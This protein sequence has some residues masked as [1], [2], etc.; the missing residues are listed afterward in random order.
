MNLASWAGSRGRLRTALAPGLDRRTRHRTVRAE[1]TTVAGLWLQPR[2]TGLAVIEE[3]AGVRRHCFDGPVAAVGA[4]DGRN[5]DHPRNMPTPALNRQRL[6]NR[7]KSKP[8]HH[9]GCDSLDTS[10][11]GLPRRSTSAVGECQSQE[12]FS[13]RPRH[14]IVGSR[15][16]L[17]MPARLSTSSCACTACDSGMTR[18]ISPLKWPSAAA[19]RLRATSSGVSP[20]APMMVRWFW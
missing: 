10:S 7:T 17:P 8:T 20:V 3:L 11:P 4:R 12:C 9:P 2:R 16:T 5:E 1:H 6:V 13:L 14:H 15:I 18:S 19:L